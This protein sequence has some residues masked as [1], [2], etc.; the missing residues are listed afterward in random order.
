[1]V[2]HEGTPLSGCELSEQDSTVGPKFA[3][4]SFLPHGILLGSAF[5]KPCL[6]AHFSNSLVPEGEHFAYAEK[7]QYAPSEHDREN[8]A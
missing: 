1:M 5:P 4:R 6:F 3:P 2:L 8:A 7:V